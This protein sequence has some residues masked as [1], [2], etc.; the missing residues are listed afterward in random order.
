MNTAVNVRTSRRAT[1]WDRIIVTGPFRRGFE[2]VRT[3]A[4]WAREYDSRSVQWQFF[5]EMGRIFAADPSSSL[6][7]KLPKSRRAVLHELCRAAGDS[8]SFKTEAG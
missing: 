3:R 7:R 8:F 4:G 1:A 6:W 2:D 5:Y